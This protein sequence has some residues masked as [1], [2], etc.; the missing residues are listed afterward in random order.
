MLSWLVHEHG[1]EPH[2][3][4]FDKSARKDGT[5]S[6]ADFTYDQQHDVYRCPGGTALRTTGS[7]V[8]DGA[9]MLYSALQR[10]CAGCVLKPRCCP[11]TPAQRSRARSIK[12]RATWPDRSP[13]HEKATSRRLRKK[14]CSSL[15]SNASSSSIGYG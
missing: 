13:T 9:T 2:V 6:R 5:F 8:N 15:D 7:L 1:I 12:V 3:T 10:E 4:L 11:N 14:R